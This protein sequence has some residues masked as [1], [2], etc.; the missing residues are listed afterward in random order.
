MRYIK[1]F[2]ENTENEGKNDSL[3]EVI[4]LAKECIKSCEECKEECEKEG[5]SES[6]KACKECIKVCEL[7]IYSAENELR[8]FNL[9]KDLAFKV[10]TDCSHVCSDEGEGICV[11][12]CQ[13]FTEKLELLESNSNTEE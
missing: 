9:V 5:H 3:E 4:N 2:N 11:E 12:A 1:K 13:D 6:I 10:A 7:F 8:N